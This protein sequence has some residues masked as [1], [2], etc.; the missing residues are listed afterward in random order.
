MP[1][2]GKLTTLKSKQNMAN[3]HWHRAPYCCAVANMTTCIVNI[4]TKVLKP[5]VQIIVK[6]ATL[7]LHCSLHAYHSQ[8]CEAGCKDCRSV[9]ICLPYHSSFTFISIPLVKE[10]QAAHES[11][12]G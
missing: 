6:E 7:H 11:L 8:L 2:S 4:L 1:D 9:V 10:V 12:T 5:C 3:A